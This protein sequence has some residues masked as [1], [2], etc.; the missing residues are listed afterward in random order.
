M[1]SLKLK[2]IPT[3]L[4]ALGALVLYLY[5]RDTKIENEIN[6]NKFVAVGKVVEFRENSKTSNHIVYAFYFNGKLYEGYQSCK[7]LIFETGKLYKVDVATI[8]PEHSRIH[9]DKEVKDSFEIVNAGFTF[10]NVSNR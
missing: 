2:V 7:D 10:G 8:N 9:L 6:E 1:K 5:I 3:V 4:F